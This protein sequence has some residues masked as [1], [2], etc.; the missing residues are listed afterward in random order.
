MSEDYIAADPH[1]RI[2]PARRRIRDPRH[3]GLAA[4]DFGTSNSTVTLHDPNLPPPVLPMPADQRAVL[5]RAVVRMLRSEPQVEEIIDRSAGQCRAEWDTLRTR[6]ARELTGG[7][8]PESLADAVEAE[9]GAHHPL[10]YDVLLAL[11]LAQAGGTAPFAGW[12]ADR[13]HG[14]YDEAFGT[15]ALEHYSLFPVRLDNATDEDEVPSRLDITAVDPDLSVRLG[16]PQALG[17][18]LAAPLRGLKHQLDKPDFRH[19]LKGG[20][21]WVELEPLLGGAFAFLLDRTDEFTHAHPDRLEDAPID[22]VVAT[23]PT[24][25]PPAVRRRLESVIGGLL[26]VGEVDLRYDEAIA[27]ALFFLMRDLGANHTIG[28]EALRARFRAVPGDER[29][30][31]ENTLVVDVGGGTTDIALIT[32]HLY[33]ETPELR[34][35]PP[36]STGRHYRV[37]PRLRGTSGRSRRG[38]DFLTLQVFHLIKAMIADH[39]LTLPD[40]G[41]D[42]FAEEPETWAVWRRDT[43]ARLDPALRTEDGRYR[44]GSLVAQSRLALQ[45]DTAVA[46]PPAGQ[47]ARDNVELVIGTRT[48]GWHADALAA[49]EKAF[50]TLW[51]LAEAAKIGIGPHRAYGFPA[52]KVQDIARA[53]VP[54]P[55]GL[56]PGIGSDLDPLTYEDFE[57]VCRPMLEEISRLAAALARTRLT[58]GERLDRVILTGK[59]SQL[60]LASEVVS[61]EL[62]TGQGPQ[63]RPVQVVVERTYA[64]NAASMGAAWA[65]SMSSYDVAEP[66]EELLRQGATSVS[67]EVDNLLLDLPCTLSMRGS[68]D[69]NRALLKVGTPFQELPGGRLRAYATIGLLPNRLVILR[70]VDGGQPLPW[71]MFRWSDLNVR[72]AEESGLRLDPQIWPRQIRCGIEADGGLDVSLLLWRGERPVYRVDRTSMAVR[73]PLADGAVPDLDRL[74]DRILVAGASAAPARPALRGDP[75][76]TRERFADEEGAVRPA[77]LGHAPLPPP[78]E[79][80]RWAFLL[81]D[82]QGR[83]QLLGRLAATP[84]PLVPHLV[85]VDEEGA[86]R[87]HAGDPP[88]WTGD[89]PI[90]IEHRPGMVYRHPLGTPRSENDDHDNP[91]DGTH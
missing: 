60:G 15:P 81:H 27:A 47:R 23:Y 26:G 37:V 68:S 33:D 7:G 22:H 14:C 55:A 83:Q 24:M 88:L 16:R 56:P 34:D 62:R 54:A 49:R 82:E 1:R 74:A 65:A 61:R 64:K 67:I 52:D 43:I 80:G 79:D 86:I 50:T 35:A 75:A 31:A 17:S 32:T 36:G 87:V 59:A 84:G 25:A 19:P 39:L 42:A 48:A 44:P 69:Q 76:P 77:L 70:E 45:R 38:G 72:L 10:L 5:G 6:L 58:G 8:T 30:R 11:E 2:Q 73:I 21:R 20:E 53:V 91:F 13:L 40:P 85:S 63:G 3:N 18:P 51:E 29:H 78:D 46:E 66:D 41:D 12:L 71:G 90:D 57:T 89:S 28:V 9:E 4:V